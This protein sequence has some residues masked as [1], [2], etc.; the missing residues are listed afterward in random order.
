MAI[1][2]ALRALNITGKVITTPFSYVATT[3][4][5]VWEGIEPVFA[6]VD[7]NTLN[8]DHG[9]LEK[10][11]DGQTQAILATHCFGNPCDVEAIQEVADHFGLKVIYD[12]AHCFGSTWKGRSVFSYGDV[13]IL[14]LHA[15]KIFHCI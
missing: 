15:T 11:V 1:Q 7:P 4:S 3:T 10:V 13:S 6:D 2:L 14:S 9:T 5:L 8:L 12:G